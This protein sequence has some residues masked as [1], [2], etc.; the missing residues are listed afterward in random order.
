MLAKNVEISYNLFEFDLIGLNY[1]GYK[2]NKNC[3]GK[4]AVVL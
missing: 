4:Q 2:R 1:E 3:N